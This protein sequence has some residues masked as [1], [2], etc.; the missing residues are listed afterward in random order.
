MQI[1][2]LIVGILYTVGLGLWVMKQ[3]DAFL[4]GPDFHPYWDQ[5]EEQS[6][7]D[8]TKDDKP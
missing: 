2:A 3:V 1:T 7:A 6:A 8:R 4:R 5:S